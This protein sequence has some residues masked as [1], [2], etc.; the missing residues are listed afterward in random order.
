MDEYDSLH[1]E[2]QREVDKVE[3]N[4]RKKQKDAKC[5]EFYEKI[6]P[7]LRKQREEKER[8]IQKQ[9]AAAELV[10]KQR[11]AEASLVVA[12]N[13]QGTSVTAT[14]TITTQLSQQG[15]ETNNLMQ[16]LTIESTPAELNAIEVWIMIRIGIWMWKIFDIFF[17]WRRKGNGFI[18]WQWFRHF[19]LMNVNWG[20]D[21]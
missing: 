13:S 3:N 12:S 18:S 14:A 21:L 4:A 20:I 8:L 17:D 1:A 19:V 5:R 9:R 2:W 11:K 7:E 10:Q 6:F 15:G 16:N